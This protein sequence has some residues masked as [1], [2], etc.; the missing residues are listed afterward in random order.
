MKQSTADKLVIIMDALIIIT[1]IFTM[2]FLYIY[3]NP[4]AIK[5]DP[6]YAVKKVPEAS[7]SLNGEVIF[8]NR[9]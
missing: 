9:K 3:I 2:T 1:L 6:Y 4:P 5:S 7:C 8:D